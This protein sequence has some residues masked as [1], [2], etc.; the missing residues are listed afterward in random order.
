[1]CNTEAGPVKHNLNIT[2]LVRLYEINTLI[3][4]NCL[5]LAENLANEILHL[6]LFLFR[7]IF[8]TC[9]QV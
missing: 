4:E 2:I 1:M 5:N 8:R 6:K 9:Q 7:L 3:T